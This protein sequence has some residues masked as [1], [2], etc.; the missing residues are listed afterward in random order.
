ML[1]RD[2]RV[3]G[4][5]WHERTG[6]GHAE[7]NAL[8]NATEDPKG[9]TAYVSME[10]CAF[11]GRTPACAKTLVAARVAR[12]VGAMTDPHP[13]VA[14]AGY[15]LLRD[16]RVRVETTELEAAW[17]LNPGYVRR[18]R[19]ERPYV[20]IKLAVSLDGRTA[21]ADGTSQWITGEAA[22]ADVQYWR[23][24]SCAIVT[25]GGTVR[26]DDPAL[27]VRDARYALDG[28]IRQPLRVVLSRSGNISPDAQLWKAGPGGDVMLMAPAGA[29]A[30]PSLDVQGIDPTNLADVLDALGALECNEVLVE[31]GPTLAGA[32]LETELWDELVLYVAPKLLGSDA[33]P[34]ALLP[35]S[36]MTEA[37]TGRIVDQSSVGDDIRIIV[38]RETAA[39]T[40]RA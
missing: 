8:A 38:A 16:A 14:G 21:M 29:A 5:G 10:P 6:E 32:F 17:A 25:G 19:G 9:C 15:K 36:R 4:R 24:R 18:V 34:L 23:A 20:R 31:A 35:L 22:R 40:S 39:D 13:L 30:H 11:E 26:S 1:A 33:R 27:T 37:V 7:V 12:V 3:I 2:G 28:V